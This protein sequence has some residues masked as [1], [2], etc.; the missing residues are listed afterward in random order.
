[1]TQS[2][3]MKFG[4]Q[5]YKTSCTFFVTHFSVPLDP[6]TRRQRERR[7][8]SEFVFFQPL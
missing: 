1:M 5:C 2:N 6:T 4:L 3:R 8:K 7:L